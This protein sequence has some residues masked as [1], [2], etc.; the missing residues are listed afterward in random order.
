MRGEEGVLGPSPSL[1]NVL[2]APALEGARLPL[3]DFADPGVGG[4]N[5]DAGVAGVAG[6]VGETSTGVTMAG[7]RAFASDDLDLTPYFFSAR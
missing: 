3:E 4:R 7:G 6:E 1:E 2:S 5:A